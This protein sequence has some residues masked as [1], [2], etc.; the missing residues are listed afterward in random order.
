MKILFITPTGGRTGSEM[1]L[2]YLIKYIKGNIETIIYSRQNGE[3][4]AKD[5][6]ANQTFINKTRKGFLYK[7]YEG[8]YYKLFK[9]TPEISKIK[10]IHQSVN[11]NF[12]YLN[13]MMSPDIVQLAIT[14]NVKYFLHVHELITIYDELREEPFRT[15]L[16]NATFIICCSSI[17]QKRINQMGFKNTI[18]LHEYIDTNQIKIGQNR[19]VMRRKY[20]IPE[21]SFVWLMSG[22]MNLR[23]GYDLIP[24]LLVNMPKN[25]YFVW[26]GSKKD[27][28]LN[29][30]IEQRV[31][32]ENLNFIYLGSHSS[33]YYD[34]FNIAD[35]FV[36]TARED[37]FPLVMIEAA[38]LQ[39]PIVGFNSGG[40]AE[41]VLD[42][43]GKVVDSFNPKDL[44][45]AMIEVEMGKVKID[46]E[47]LRNRALEFDVKNQIGKWEQ[48]FSNLNLK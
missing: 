45:D 42:G 40:I 10:R 9:H 27:A 43:M 20:N 29:Y 28:G 14:L 37:P 30:Y 33:D 1:M 7:I 12:W 13:T 11:P 8:I 36:L 39:K 18:L 21:N 19:E 15:Q 17:V 31:Q 16:Q 38:Y 3:L 35:G 26:L 48:L 5:S 32:L 41:F 46:K 2:W 47:I 6:P 34:F 25:S 4:F 23:K 44:G 22:S 24:D